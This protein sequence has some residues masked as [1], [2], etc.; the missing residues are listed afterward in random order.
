MIIIIIII[1]IIFTFSLGGNC[2][3]TMIATLSVEKRNI[4]VHIGVYV[5]CYL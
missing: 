2:M 5:W 1:I 4:E 3:T